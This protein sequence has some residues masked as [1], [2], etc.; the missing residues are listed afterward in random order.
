MFLSEFE[1]HHL[2]SAEWKHRDKLVCYKYIFSGLEW[3]LASSGA[4]QK[5]DCDWNSEFYNEDIT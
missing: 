3:I 2:P 5:Y 4:L 1:Y